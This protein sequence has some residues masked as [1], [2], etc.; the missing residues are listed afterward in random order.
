M[1]Q[2]I[3]L[4]GKTQ[5]IIFIAS[6]FIFFGLL[7]M[8]LL[9]IGGDSDFDIGGD[10]DI[11]LDI[12]VDVDVSM[13]ADLGAE[14]FQAAFNYPIMLM[15]TF[16]FGW[17]GMVGIAGTEMLSSYIP[18]LAP[19]KVT[20]ASATISGIICYQLAAITARGFSKVMPS[21]QNHGG[22]SKDLVGKRAKVLSTTIECPNMGR[23]SATDEYGHTYILNA[24]LLD[25]ESKVSK[26]GIIEIVD[27][28]LAT[29]SCTC[30]NI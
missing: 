12:D 5:N 22:P 13:D 23:V 26:G 7:S 27:F 18:T 19:W 10:I 17:F 15:I 25:G 1:D 30:R 4:L 8:Q 28:D 11:D 21:I 24:R 16:F 14:G 3:D 6:E 2:L 9:G 29:Q 20:L